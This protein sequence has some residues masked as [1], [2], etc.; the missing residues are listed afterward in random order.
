MNIGDAILL[1]SNTPIIAQEANFDLTIDQ[2][3]ASPN[4]GPA[5]PS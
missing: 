3:V 5:Q 4:F 2:G 1:Q